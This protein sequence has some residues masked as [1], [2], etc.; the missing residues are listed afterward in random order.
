M[1]HV[2]LSLLDLERVDAGSSAREMERWFLSAE[3]YQS[4]L[5]IQR[6]CRPSGVQPFDARSA[7]VQGLEHVRAIASRTA[8]RF[9]MTNCHG[10]PALF[11]GFSSRH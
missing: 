3:K 2:T 9:V 11:E 8:A 10:C 1:I 7:L 6:A 5:P 4:L